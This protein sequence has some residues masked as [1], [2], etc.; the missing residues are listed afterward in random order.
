MPLCIDAVAEARDEA[1]RVETPDVHFVFLDDALPRGL[2]R[3]LDIDQDHH[4]V[5]AREKR[6]GCEA[7]NIERIEAGE[8]GRRALAPAPASQLG[9]LLRAG[10]VFPIDGLGQ[11]RRYRRDVAAS[12][13]VVYLLRRLQMIHAEYPLFACY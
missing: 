10:D 11:P 7:V 4:E 3:A 8:K 13:G 5:F 6:L 9:D 1:L 2:H 12:E